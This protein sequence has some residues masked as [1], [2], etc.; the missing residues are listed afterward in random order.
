MTSTDLPVQTGS[1]W[2]GLDI[3]GNKRWIACLLS[4]GGKDGRFQASFQVACMGECPSFLK[5]AVIVGIDVPIKF[6]N[7]EVRRCDVEARKVAPAAT[8]FNTPSLAVVEKYEKEPS[9]NYQALS[10]LN[11]RY[12]HNVHGRP[13]GITKQTYG[14]LPY[15][16]AARRLFSALNGRLL[17]VHPEVSFVFLAGKSLP[18]KKT[19]MGYMAR[20][21][22]LFRAGIK[23]IER[24]LPRS[25]RHDYLDAAVVAFT[26]YCVDRGLY[27][28]LGSKGDSIYYPNV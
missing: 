22:L 28:C 6:Q 11:K 27:R 18:R 4:P 21:G 12:Q 7:G 9:L 23:G 15:I 3:Y 17:E 8:V 1:F 20:I 24:E 5:E 2:V 13:V 26:A 25:H 14:L 16:A 19:D 10:G